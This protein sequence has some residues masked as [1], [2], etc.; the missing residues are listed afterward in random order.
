MSETIVAPPMWSTPASKLVLPVDA[1]RDQ[2]IAA[3]RLGL[4]GSD[5]STV[6]GLNPYSSLYSLWLD[7]TGRAPEKPQTDAMEWG[8][9]LEPVIREWF[10]DTTGI[11]V[12]RAGLMQSKARP[13]Q[14]VNL[15]G[16]T[17][18][19]G[20]CEWKTTNWRTD[21][22]EIWQDGQVPDHAEI[23]VQH[24]MAV[25]GRGH[26]HCVVLIDG[27]TPLHRVIGRDDDLIATLT[28]LERA[29]WHDYVLAD[30]EPPVDGS[31]A[32]ANA[33]KTRYGV[34]KSELV[35]AGP[36]VL[37]L[38]AQLEQAKAAAKAAD[39][40]QTEIENRLRAICGDATD[41]AVQG[42]IVVTLHQ[43]GTFSERRF[44]TENPDLV[45][46]FTTQIDA[47]DVG[48]LKTER[49]EVYARYRARVLRTPKPKPAKKGN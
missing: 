34:A 25:T 4:G 37:D 6:A 26:A 22:A 11:P 32:T 8:H 12:R 7:K 2:W 39:A 19:G 16:L 30:V 27:R 44:R 1:P 20:I 21:D 33:L 31:E 49:P 36:E 42:D 29:F 48:R 18:D 43:N 17:A 41:L 28:E 45:E 46:Q 40:H 9:R 15:D 3:R 13:W 35:S 23:Q 47:L 5:A 38:R 24:G 14:L 10:T